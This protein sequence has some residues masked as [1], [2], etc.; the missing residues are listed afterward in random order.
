LSYVPSTS[1]NDEPIAFQD[2]IT[3][4]GN[5]TASGRPYPLSYDL[6][7]VVTAQDIFGSWS[8]WETVAFTSPIEGPQAPAVVS[9]QLDNSGRLVVDFSWDWA[10]RSP[11]FIEL[12]GA[13]LD[14]P[15]NVLASARIDF[16]GQDQG[17]TGADIVPLSI[18]KAPTSWGA[19]QDKDEPGL[20]L[21]RW[22]A[23]V[24]LSF[25]GARWREFGVWARG[26][27]HL[28]RLEFGGNTSWNTSPWTAPV[29]TRVWAIVQ[30]DP[31]F[32]EPPEAPFW[33]S[34]PD[35][36]GVSRFTLNWPAVP[37]AE[38]YLVYEA[39]E[40]ALLSANDMGSPDTAVPY[41]VRLA[42]LRGADIV[43]KQRTFRRLN[44]EP[45]TEARYEVTLPR[46]SRVIHF[47]AITTMSANKIEGHWP[48]DN[49]MFVAVA[50]PRVSQS[51]LPGIS[52][53][54]APGAPQQ[55]AV[56]IE[57]SGGS[58]GR[59]ELY[60]TDVK[61]AAEDVGSMGPPIA[62][63]NAP[64]GIVQFTDAGVT[65]GWYPHHYRAVAWSA[66]D[67]LLGLV[68]ARS[69][70][71]PAV[72]ILVPPAD[73]PEIDNIRTNEPYSTA[74]HSLIAWTC[75]A[76]R[77][78]TP[79]G[80]HVFV[81]EAQS[82]EDAI[83]YYRIEQALDATIPVESLDVPG[84]GAA[85]IYA[86]DDGTFWHYRAWAPRQGNME[87]FLTLKII[88]PLGRIARKIISVGPLD[89]DQEWVTIPP[90][91]DL[92]H[93]EHGD[94]MGIDILSAHDLGLRVHYEYTQQEPGY[95]HEQVVSISPPA[96]TVVAAGTIVTVTL[97]L[98]G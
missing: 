60:R 78:R 35:A 49:R 25:D 65:P 16:G 76:P 34:L 45:V 55:V 75:Q 22:T 56:K 4:T 97:N 88:D 7:Y 30:L 23:Q 57:L 93:V 21:Y 36:A 12:S 37:N 80:P 95:D 47:F 73:V 41:H 10:D 32:V 28:H 8:D 64:G 18:E 40:T 82:S 53:A 52:A 87:F 94:D 90:W 79:V 24:P 11:A 9:V 62:S 50:V 72:S 85:E 92:E 63:L 29:A 20:R 3:R 83:A 67:D 51:P 1:R 44:E 13:W 17:Q 19:P 96:G 26:Q 42:T 31:P 48:N 68:E 81:L 89:P 5:G 69:A 71:S 86:I 74:T 77:R 39:T 6:S 91:P 27:Q 46:G 58:G 54:P 2:H 61:D 98:L 43:G 14:Q 66:R 59:V 84:P 38:G 33:A 15:G 70:A